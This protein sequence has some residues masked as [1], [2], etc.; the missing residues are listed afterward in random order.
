[1]IDSLNGDVLEIGVDHVVLDCHGVGYLVH[2]PATVLAQ[3]PQQGKIRLHVHYSVSVD[4][5]SGSSD[6]RLYGF[7]HRDDRQLFRRLIDVQGVSATIGM[8]IMG[9]RSAAEIHTAILVGDESMLKG[10][11]GIG[12][13]LA[14]RIIAELKGKLSGVQMPTSGA[15]IPGGN[16][17]RSE[18]LSALT[19]LGLDRL[20]AERALHR[21]L[22]ER[23]GDMPTVEELIKLTLKD[24]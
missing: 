1:M 23:A 9:A 14:Q 7:H 4:V 8:M 5:R 3:L 19:S 24:L 2:A 16:T 13:K 15:P 6:H 22:Q 18:A 10:V 20:K 12:P 17:L 21:V 11:K